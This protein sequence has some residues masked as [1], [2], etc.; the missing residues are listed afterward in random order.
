MKK[1][2]FLM[3]MIV[4]FGWLNVVVK[5]DEKP[6]K[7]VC[8]EEYEKKWTKFNEKILDDI[9]SS[10]NLDLEGF[11]E[12]TFDDLNNMKIGKKNEDIQSLQHL[13]VGNSIGSMRLFLDGNRG[14]FL[15]KRI[16]GNNVLKE[17]NQMS[18][19]GLWGVMSE[20]EVK[21]K[22]IKWGKAFDLSFIFIYKKT[23]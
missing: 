15:F 9:F 11:N 4:L 20:H 17:I 22:K 16:N 3:L 6:P 18:N 2:V 19:G 13:F 7:K 23:Y 12:V 10:Y 21:G 8:I 1:R 5:A 14:Y